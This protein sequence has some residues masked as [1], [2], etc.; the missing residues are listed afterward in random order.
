MVH[1][2]APPARFFMGCRYPDFLSDNA[3]MKEARILGIAAI[4]DDK[5]SERPY[6][7]ALEIETPSKKISDARDTFFKTEVVG[8]C[9]KLLFKVGR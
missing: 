5:S 7:P 3:I 1:A 2:S 8:A 6:R 4:M 9:P